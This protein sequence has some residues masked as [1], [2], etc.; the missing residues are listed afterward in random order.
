ML[1]GRCGRRTREGISLRCQR[2]WAR[3]AQPN[4]SH[5]SPPTV[6]SLERLIAQK[7]SSAPESPRVEEELIF[8]IMKPVARSC[9]IGKAAQGR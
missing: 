9:L 7:N 3:A 2:A 6:R 1:S 5:H 8:G 4:F